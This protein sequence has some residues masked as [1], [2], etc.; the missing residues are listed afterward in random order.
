MFS[1]TTIAAST[2]MPIANARPAS[3]ITLIVRPSAA[4]A[5]NAPITDTGIASETTSDARTERRNNSSSTAA[6]APPT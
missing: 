3:E 1:S 2:T 6:N 4:I 5:T